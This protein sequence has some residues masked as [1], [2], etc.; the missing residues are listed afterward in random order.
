LKWVK[1]REIKFQME[2]KIER[3][4]ASKSDSLSTFAVSSSYTDQLSELWEN[5]DEFR[6]FFE[7]ESR[8]SERWF[9]RFK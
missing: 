5:E 1:R 4:V 3:D 6:L 8:F 9:G 7:N 2:E